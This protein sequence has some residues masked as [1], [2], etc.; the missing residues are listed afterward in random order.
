MA[1]EQD[2]MMLQFLRRELICGTVTEQN[3]MLDTIADRFERLIKL[4]KAVND[5]CCMYGSGVSCPYYAEYL[6]KYKDIDEA[7]DRLAYEKCDCCRLG[8]V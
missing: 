7:M 2:K 5:Y 6:S 8:D 3:A 4:E 1:S